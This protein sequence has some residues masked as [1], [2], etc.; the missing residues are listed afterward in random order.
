MVFAPIWILY[1]TVAGKRTLLNFYC[2]IEELLKIRIVAMPLILLV[3]L[4]WMWNIVK[5]L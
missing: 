1:D 3:L 4:N 2:K 5:G